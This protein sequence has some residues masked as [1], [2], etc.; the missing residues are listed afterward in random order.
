MIN[1]PISTKGPVIASSSTLNKRYLISSGLLSRWFI[2]SILMNFQI[3]LLILFKKLIISD[4]IWLWQIPHFYNCFTNV[5]IE[6]FVI[7]KKK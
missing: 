4:I 5:I 1:I 3:F 7:F 2:S 6:E